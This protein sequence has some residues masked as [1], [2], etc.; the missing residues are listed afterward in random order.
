MGSISRAGRRVFS[1][2]PKQSGVSAPVTSAEFEAAAPTILL[3]EA[4]SEGRRYP[5]MEHWLPLFHDRLETIFRLSAGH[6][7][8]AGALLLED[9]AH[10]RFTQIADYY[11]ARRDALKQGGDAASQTAAGGKRFISARQS[12][13]SGSAPRQLVR[14]TPFA[15]PEASA[16]DV[17]AR[18]GHNLAAERAEP[19][20]NVF[21]ALTAPCGQVCRPRGKRVT[22]TLW[23]EG[24]RERMGHVLAD[25][26]LH[27]LAPVADWSRRWLC[28]S[29]PS[30]WSAAIESGF[31][32]DDVAIV[33]EQDILGDRL[34]RP[35]RAARRSR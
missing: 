26:K 6:G 29:R 10:E 13:R 35:R 24:A 16:F 25:H 23:S 7:D 27:N 32:T 31:E 17:G 21:E 4:V 20:A 2:L 5:G 14:L 11:D 8:S 30:R 15:V 28:P 34:V 12:G 22:I 1:S 33:S 3:Y 9:A 18:Q 19:D